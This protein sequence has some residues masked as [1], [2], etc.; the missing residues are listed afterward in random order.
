MY[1]GISFV[2]R[3]YSLK[4]QLNSIK[5]FMPHSVRTIISILYIILHTYTEVAAVGE[6]KNRLAI[7]ISDRF[8]VYREYLYRVGIVGTLV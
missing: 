2:L 4:T 6:H 7:A 8:R 5:I 1:A 3:I